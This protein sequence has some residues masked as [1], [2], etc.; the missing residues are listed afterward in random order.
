M[1]VLMAR[2]LGPQGSQLLSF[3]DV[4]VY[5]KM[6]AYE[7]MYKL[8]KGLRDMLILHSGLAHLEPYQYP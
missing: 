3:F 7:H 5:V 2:N 6:R 4:F 1:H 8:P